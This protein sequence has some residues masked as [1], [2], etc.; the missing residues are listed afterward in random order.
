MPAIT[1]SY[2]NC[3]V[4]LYR[5]REDALEGVATG[6]SGFLVAVPSRHGDPQPYLHVVTNRH[7]GNG[8]NCVVRVNTRD[9]NSE[10]VATDPAEWVLST[11]DDLAAYPFSAPDQAIWN[12]I[13]LDMFLGEACAI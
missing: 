13:P 2:L 8:G 11:D 1:P 5:T 12:A 6:G 10:A 4:Y 9:G 7:V 3:T